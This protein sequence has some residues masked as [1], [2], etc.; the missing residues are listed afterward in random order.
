[1]ASQ[2]KGVKRQLEESSPQPAKKTFM[3]KSTGISSPSLTPARNTGNI[4]AN[5]INTIN[6][7]SQS[8]NATCSTPKGNNSKCQAISATS[9]TRSSQSVSQ[10]PGNNDTEVVPS[11]IPACPTH[12]KRCNM[13]EVR[14][15]GTN[16]GRWFFSCVLRNCNFFEVSYVPLI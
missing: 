10:K 15:E 4:P 1:M 12:K 5:G 11:K 3:F 9:T 6:M 7:K 2:C 8:L 16:K 13:K 14:K